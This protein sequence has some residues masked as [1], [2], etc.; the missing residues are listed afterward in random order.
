MN[1]CD[2]QIKL[3]SNRASI[4]NDPRESRVGRAVRP[5]R[6]ELRRFMAHKRK[7][8]VVGGW[9]PPRDPQW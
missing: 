5:A 2:R 8:K 9:E 6:T 1:I 4:C 7:Q 3:V